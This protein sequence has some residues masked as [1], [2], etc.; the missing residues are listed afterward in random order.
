MAISVV[1]RLLFRCC[2]FDVVWTSSILAMTQ[3]NLPVL[4]WF[5]NGWRQYLLHKFAECHRP[6]WTIVDLINKYIYI[7]CIY[8]YMYNNLYIYS[9]Y[10]STSELTRAFLDSEVG[11]TNVGFILPHFHSNGRS[12]NHAIIMHGDWDFLYTIAGVGTPK[13]LKSEVLKQDGFCWLT[14]RLVSTSLELS[15]FYRE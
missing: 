1:T 12:L 3:R 11:E 5:S 7:Y 10:K 9:L 4:R 6:M 15:R 8:I 14:W 13:K 2:I